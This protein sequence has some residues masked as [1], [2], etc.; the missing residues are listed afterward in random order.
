MESSIGNLIINTKGIENNSDI[1]NKLSDFEILQIL[2][3]GA[4][5]FVA[6]VKSKLNLR[7]YALKKYDSEYLTKPEAKKYVINESIFMKQLNNENVVRLYNNF[8]DKDDLYLVMEYMDGGDLY[9]FLDAHMNLNLR[10]NEEK[11][12]DIFGQCL[13]GLVYL[14]QKGLLH[15][16]IKPANILMNSKGEVKYSDFNVSAIINSDKA[17]DFIKEKNKE[18]NLLNNMTVVGSGDYTAP[19]ILQKWSY[20]EKIDLWSVGVIL[21]NMTTGC[22]PFSTDGEDKDIDNEVLEKDIQFDVIAHEDIRN[23]CMRLLEKYPARRFNAKTA[24]NEAIRI[25]NLLE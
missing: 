3:K 9:T 20:S 22:Q 1:G 17:R 12:W 15:R 5:G 7:I 13:R 10:I 18:E 25:R 8:K 16:D 19:E 4:Y 21:F 23:L 24:L 11:L 6:K 2:G 14:H